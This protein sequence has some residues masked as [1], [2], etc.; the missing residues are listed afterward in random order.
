M[1]GPLIRASI[2]S[3][4]GK[5]KHVALS[6]EEIEFRFGNHAAAIEG[7]TDPEKHQKLRD[8]WKEIAGFLNET[9]VD[10]RA[11]SVMFTELETAA[12]WSHKALAKEK[13][14]S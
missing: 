6:K 7:P 13:R 11:K 4:H 12:M 9:L 10:G 5:G 2:F 1:R 8:I 14:G 3:A